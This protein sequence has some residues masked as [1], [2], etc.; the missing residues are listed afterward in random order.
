MYGILSS[1]SSSSS[2]SAPTQRS[3]RRPSPR[4]RPLP[5]G[6]IVACTVKVRY[7][8]L[9][10]KKKPALKL[11]EYAWGGRSLGRSK[12]NSVMRISEKR[13]EH[14]YSNGKHTIDVGKPKFA[15]VK[16][17]PQDSKTNRAMLQQRAA[18]PVASGA[19]RSR[20]SSNREAAADERR[21]RSRAPS[22]DRGKWPGWYGFYDPP[23]ADPDDDEYPWLW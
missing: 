14:L 6:P 5:E 20:A 8:L 19:L 16:K 15:W 3:S 9:P 1:S 22:S 21:P 17:I 11:A 4:P 7:V 18:S 12:G 10:E 2:S 23:K 13:T